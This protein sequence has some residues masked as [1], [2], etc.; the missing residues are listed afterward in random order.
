LLL[1]PWLIFWVAFFQGVR[2]SAPTGCS[3]QACGGVGILF[4]RLHVDYASSWYV[5]GF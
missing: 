1:G 5:L 2:A 3:P 4:Q